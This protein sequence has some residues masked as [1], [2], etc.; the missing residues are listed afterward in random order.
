MK[1]IGFLFVPFSSRLSQQKSVIER[2]AQGYGCRDVALQMRNNAGHDLY[3][4]ISQGNVASY[5]QCYADYAVQVGQTWRSVEV[6]DGERKRGHPNILVAN[7]QYAGIQSINNL[8]HAF[9]LGLKARF[10]R[11]LRAFVNAWRA[12]H[13]RSFHD[14]TCES[15]TMMHSL[16]QPPNQRG[17][18]DHSYADNRSLANP[19]DVHEIAS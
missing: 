3:A 15:L 7:L 9:A 18:C 2:V 8:G 17:D 6:N 4:G 12:A 10:S 11:S 5:G 16:R 1:S 19:A 14:V 13:V